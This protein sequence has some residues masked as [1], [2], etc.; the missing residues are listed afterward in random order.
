MDA[1][2][3]TI[4]KPLSA[5]PTGSEGSISSKWPRGAVGC[6]TYD[7]PD[8]TEQTKR[9]HQL[10]QQPH[11]RKTTTDP[12]KWCFPIGFLLFQGSI[13]RWHVRFRTFDQSLIATAAGEASQLGQ[14]KHT[15]ALERPA[16]GQ[17]WLNGE[18]WPKLMPVIDLLLPS[19]YGMSW[20]NLYLMFFW[21]DILTYHWK[22]GIVG[23]LLYDVHGY[24]IFQLGLFNSDPHAGN[25]GDSKDSGRMK[26]TCSGFRRMA[27]RRRKKGSSKLL[28]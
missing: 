6:E 23:R 5:D 2:V 22:S 17:V 13:S 3:K 26:G 21:V 7:P 9:N 1:I 15:C 28:N 11:P 12:N 14:A 25:A 4:E 24:E 10:K 19:S 20:I 8:L 18:L 27:S 16:P